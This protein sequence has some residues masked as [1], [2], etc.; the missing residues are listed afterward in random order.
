MLISL[1]LTTSHSLYRIIAV[2]LVSLFLSACS[3]QLSEQHA[4]LQKLPEQSQQVIFVQNL[5]WSHSQA[6][7]Q[8]FE[9]QQGEWQKVAA[10][11][12]VQLGRNGLAWGRG[13][14]QIQDLNNIKQEGDGK[15]PAGIFKLGSS[16]GY[17]KSAL[18]GQ[19]Y[20]YRQAGSRDYYIDDSTSNDYNQWVNIAAHLENTPKQYWKS[21]EKMRR[22]DA[23]YEL[24]IEIEHNKQ[25]IVPNAGSAIFMHVWK[26]KDTS[27]AGCT[28]MSKY[29]I[30]R[31]LQWLDQAKQPL[32][33]QVPFNS[34]DTL[35]LLE[36]P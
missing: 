21:Y 31:I 32:L 11:I 34:L 28:A 12:S 15:A 7:L 8:R 4:W 22:N 26:D 14:H 25:T 13:L 10:P 30:R 24:G 29:D 17:D 1:I 33:V 27:T 3:P 18:S 19:S 5:A 16:F 35:T 20:P 6:T 2:V 36:T 23:L 9:K